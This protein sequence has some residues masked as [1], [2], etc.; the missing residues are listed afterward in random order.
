MI[1]SAWKS[2]SVSTP[3]S[4]QCHYSSPAA[5]SADSLSVGKTT[6]EETSRPCVTRLLLSH[7]SCA[8]NLELPRFRNAAIVKG[9]TILTIA[10]RWQLWEAWGTSLCSS[11]RDAKRK[12]WCVGLGRQRVPCALCVWVSRKGRM[13]KCLYVTSWDKK[14][15]L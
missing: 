6:R 14:G 7:G 1:A 13:K 4:S 15:L 5:S 11:A 3:V 12:S 9:C 8:E 10:K 2:I